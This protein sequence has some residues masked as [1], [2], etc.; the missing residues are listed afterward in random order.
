MVAG[1]WNGEGRFIACHRTYLDQQGDKILKASVPSPK[2]VLGAFRGGYIPVSKGRS[3]ASL[4]EAADDETIIL[5]EGIEDAVTLA[6][7]CPTAR[8]VAAVSLGNIGNVP[9]P[10]NIRELII[11]ADNDEDAQA[12][13]ALARAVDAQVSRGLRQ[14]S[15]ARAQ[16]SKD[17]NALLGAA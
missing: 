4:A 6:A 1:I 10:K 8:V 17:V 12:Q 15:V 7:A 3:R 14:V 13:A 2:K 16:G 9:I 5:T 11:C